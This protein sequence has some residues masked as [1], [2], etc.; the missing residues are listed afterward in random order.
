M[1]G[2]SRLHDEA[3]DA[4]RRSLYS[5]IEHMFDPTPRQEDDTW[6]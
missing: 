3:V 5:Q 2:L 1:G 4:V 6:I